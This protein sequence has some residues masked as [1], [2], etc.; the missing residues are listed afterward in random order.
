MV[1][2]CPDKTEV[3][4]PIPST[5]TMIEENKGI[6]KNKGKKEKINWT[7]IITFYAK[8]TS[9]IIF[10]LIIAIIVSKKINSGYYFLFVIIAFGVT[11]FGI[12]K[13]IKEYKKSLT[14]RNIKNKPEIK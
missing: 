6:K 11:C 2:R 9:W 10:P 5:L 3:D 13:E 7:P 8:T 1:E 4:G 12:Y 14:E